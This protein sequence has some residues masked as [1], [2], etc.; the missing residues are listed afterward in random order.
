MKRT[1]RSVLIRAL[2]A[3]VSVVVFYFALLFFAQRWLIFPVPPAA[4]ELPAPAGVEALRLTIDSG[5]IEA[6]Y[7]PPSISHSGPAPLLIFTH[8]NAELASQWF[9][10]FDEPRSWG[11]GVL[12]VEYPGYGRSAGAPSESS[13]TATMLAAYQWAIHD[14]RVDAARVVAVGRSIG[15]GAASALAARQPIA[16]VVLLSPFTSLSAMARRFLAPPFLIRDPFDNVAHLNARPVPVLII[17]GTH[18]TVIPMAHGR[19]LA[20]QVPGSEFEPIDAPHD[21]LP[22]WPRI[23]RFLAD[24]G[25]RKAP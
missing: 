14:P 7:L 11:F 24:H 22:P 12:L 1:P 21:Y 13:I 17:H 4:F 5:S 10:G 6:W 20:A 15:T 18:D 2:V 9:D 19:A 23:K 25:V 16:A 8:G 3:V